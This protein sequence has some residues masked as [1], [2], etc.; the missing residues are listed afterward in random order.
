MNF[1][2]RCFEKIFCLV[3]VIVVVVMIKKELRL[4]VFLVA[5]VFMDCDISKL[6]FNIYTSLVS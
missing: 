4:Q 6:N 2:N 1:G 5:F 3:V